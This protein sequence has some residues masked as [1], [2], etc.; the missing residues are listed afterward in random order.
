MG[1]QQRRYM[2]EVTWQENGTRSWQPPP[3][4]KTVVVFAS[5]EHEAAQE[6]KTEVGKIFSD[7]EVTPL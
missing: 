3:Q 7:T 4:S 1:K 5:S 2:V 6:A